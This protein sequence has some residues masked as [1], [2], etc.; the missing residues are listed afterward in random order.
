MGAAWQKLRY[1]SF[2]SQL[3][4]F[5]VRSLA[6]F[7]IHFPT[8]SHIGMQCIL[9]WAPA[10]ALEEIMAEIPVLP[11]GLKK[12]EACYILGQYS[13]LRLARILDRLFPDVTPDDDLPGDVKALLLELKDVRKEQMC[14]DRHQNIVSLCHS[15]TGPSTDVSSEAASLLLPTSRNEF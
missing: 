7:A 3:F 14:R 9:T 13:P 10:G 8:V 4:G 12:P 1:L 6:T 2:D 11:H 5:T 15:W